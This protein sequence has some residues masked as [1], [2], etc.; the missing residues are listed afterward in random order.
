M[1]WHGHRGSAFPIP[2]LATF[3]SWE[4]YPR[5]H[6][7]RRVGPALCLESA[8]KVTLLAGAQVSQPEG[9]DHTGGVGKLGNALPARPLLSCSSRES[10]FPESR[11]W[12]SWL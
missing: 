6:E 12:E 5:G 9:R 11:E 7:L 3:S 1:A 8:A 2:H 10:W 4:S